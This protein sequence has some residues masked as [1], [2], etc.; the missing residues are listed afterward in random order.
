MPPLAAAAAADAD[1][2]AAV[3]AVAVALMPPLAVALTAPFMPP[4]IRA[5]FDAIPSMIFTAIR[6]IATITKAPTI[7]FIIE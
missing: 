1:V 5:E 6:H 7:I 2:V 3:T 4:A